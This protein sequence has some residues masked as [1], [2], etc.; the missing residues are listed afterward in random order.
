[1]G[2]LHV[3]PTTVASRT[4]ATAPTPLRMKRP[5][6]SRRL[7]GTASALDLP[8]LPDEPFPDV[9]L[10]LVEIELAA[11]DLAGPEVVDGRVVLPDDV[12][13]VVHRPLVGPRQP[14]LVLGHRLGRPPEIGVEREAVREIVGRRGRSRAGVGLPVALE[15][16][17]ARVLQLGHLVHERSALFVALAAEL[18]I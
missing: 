13:E 14:V 7:S 18:L 11:P 10:Q 1:M 3:T 15:H 9:A 17:V 8:R 5:R 16:D 12:A 4:T 2:R 6:R